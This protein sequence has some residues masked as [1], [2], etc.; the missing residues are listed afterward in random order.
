MGVAD[1]IG[2]GL[3]VGI[4][5]GF[6]IDVEGSGVVGCTVTSDVAVA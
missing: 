4:G 6:G 1:S 3:V 2:V 5:V